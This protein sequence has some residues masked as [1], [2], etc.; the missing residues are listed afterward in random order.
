MTCPAFTHVMRFECPC[1]LLKARNG[2]NCPMMVPRIR[3]GLCGG[4]SPSTHSRHS[5]IRARFCLE[6]CVSH[7][8]PLLPAICRVHKG[9]IRHHQTSP[10]LPP[11]C[12]APPAQGCLASDKYLH[13]PML[14]RGNPTARAHYDWSRTRYPPPPYSALSPR[15]PTTTWR[16]HLVCASDALT[17]T[18]GYSWRPSCYRH[19]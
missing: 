8:V 16:K 13:S 9:S 19:S 7:L 4:I 17:D 6:A 2:S 18:C 1:R 11:S 14:N 3:P 10:A 15:L 5:T 12:P